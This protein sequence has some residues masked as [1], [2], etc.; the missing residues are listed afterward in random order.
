[1]SRNLAI[2]AFVGGLILGA[3]LVGAI[4]PRSATAQSDSRPGQWWIDA[5][6][7]DGVWRLNTVTG[8]LDLCAPAKGAVVCVAGP[9]PSN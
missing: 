7:A 1:M 6:G 2:A 5:A 3:A 8:R 9:P 4:G